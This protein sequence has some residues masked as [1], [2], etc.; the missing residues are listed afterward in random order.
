M[1]RNITIFAAL[2]LSLL[3][4]ASLNTIDG[5]TINYP[6]FESIQIDDSYSNIGSLIF[7]DQMGATDRLTFFVN[8]K[9]S[10]TGVHQYIIVRAKR[11]HQL[12]HYVDP[13]Q[14]KIRILE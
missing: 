1:Y 10:A 2:S 5:N 13:G 6:Q 9:S 12:V 4:C 11:P 3:G 7:P 14:K 8:P